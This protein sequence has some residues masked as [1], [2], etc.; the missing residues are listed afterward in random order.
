MKIL[1]RISV[2]IALL[3]LPSMI[4]ADDDR[5]PCIGMGFSMMGPSGDYNMMTGP[6]CE[7]CGNYHERGYGK[8]HKTLTEDEAAKKMKMFVEKHLKNYSIVS[9]SKAEVPKGDMYWAI[10]KEEKDGNELELHMNPWGYIRG[11][12]IR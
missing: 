11:P 4:S 6:A 3:V 9:F 12:F 2:V 5:K 7:D 10:I 1:A 8:K